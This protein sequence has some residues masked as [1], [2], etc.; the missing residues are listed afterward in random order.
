MAIKL[1]LASHIYSIPLTI[2]IHQSFILLTAEAEDAT[3]YAR[4]VLFLR[5]MFSP[6][7]IL[8]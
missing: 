7:L 5:V 6:S 3:V 2:I 4:C 1:K 8:H